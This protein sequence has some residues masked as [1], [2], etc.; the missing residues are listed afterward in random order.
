MITQNELVI[1]IDKLLRENKTD[2]EIIHLLSSR[3]K[4]RS[5]D[6]SAIMLCSNEIGRRATDGIEGWLKRG[7][8]GYFERTANKV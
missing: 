2:F 6:V 8:Y 4:I 1:E 5:C 7:R 3:Y